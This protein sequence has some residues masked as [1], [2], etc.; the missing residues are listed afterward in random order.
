M[1]KIL[2]AMDALHINTQAIEFSCYLA[3]LTCSRLTGVFL[4]DVLSEPAFG[5]FQQVAQMQAGGVTDTEVASARAEIT[6]ANI[7]QFRRAC[8][9]RGVVPNIHRDRGTP[10]DEVVR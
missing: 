3:R 2:L 1:E 6:D 5:A 7:L 4:E 9:S 8:E 10:L